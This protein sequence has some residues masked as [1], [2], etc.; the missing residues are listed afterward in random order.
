ML[1]LPLLLS[2]ALTACSGGEAPKK[3]TVRAGY[4]ENYVRY[5]CDCRQIGASA[6][7]SIKEAIDEER[8]SMESQCKKLLK[9]M[10]KADKGKEIV[11][12]SR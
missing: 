10:K 7:K 12:K 11:C 1:S 3:R 5:I 4:C 8:G 9:D 2:V 6:C